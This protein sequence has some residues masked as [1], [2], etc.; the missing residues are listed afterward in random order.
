LGFGGQTIA[1]R[2]GTSTVSYLHSDHLGSASA[3]TNSSGVLTSWQRFD[4]WGKVRASA[5]TMPTKQNFTGQYLDDTGLLY[6]NARYYD[7][8][9]ARFISADT[10]APGKENPQNRNRYAY[11]L[12]NP[13][14]YI[15]PT[16]HCAEDASERENQRCFDAQRELEALGLTVVELW[17]WQSQHLEW[18]L[19]AI[20]DLMS[21]GQWSVATFKANM[22]IATGGTIDLIRGGK[23]PKNWFAAVND[24]DLLH[25]NQSI[26]FYDDLFDQGKDKVKFYAVHEFAHIWDNAQGRSLSADLQDYTGSTGFRRNWPIGS[27]NFGTACYTPKGNTV[28]GYGRADAMEDWAETVAASVYPRSRFVAHL[29]PARMRYAREQ[30]GTP[31]LPS[32]QRNVR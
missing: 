30:I 16:G 12:N 15:D 3:A 23:H 10:I 17:D 32:S 6:Y 21:A 24:K 7:P 11:T 22:G 20:N 1:I 27:C 4:P 18:I 2:E 8:N 13:L 26:T 28:T 9:I 25:A 31:A 29:D 5:N 14:K 19:E